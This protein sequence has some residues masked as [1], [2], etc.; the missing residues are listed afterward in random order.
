MLFTVLMSFLLIFSS[1]ARKISFVQSSVVPAATGTVKIKKDKNNNYAI[2]ISILH[3]APPENLQPPGKTYVA[4]METEQNSTRNLGQFQ[5]NSGFLSGTL[6]ASL[7]AITTFRPG[8]I[9]ITSEM[10]PAVSYP[11]GQPVLTTKA[12]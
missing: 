4:W 10:D 6:K 12:L 5:S 11:H 8:R 7:N 3:L 1:C 9:F 2:S